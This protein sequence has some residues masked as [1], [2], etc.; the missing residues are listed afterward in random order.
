MVRFELSAISKGTGKSCLRAF[1]QSS[2]LF[3]IAGGG[4]DSFGRPI[5]SNLTCL[6][7]LT[8]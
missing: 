4:G 8:I 1:A 5:E 2:A 3:A 6:M 7:E